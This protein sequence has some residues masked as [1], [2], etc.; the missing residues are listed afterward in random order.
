MGLFL[1]LDILGL[2]YGTSVLFSYICKIKHTDIKS[3]FE[4][5]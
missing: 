4:M 5:F 2:K 3:D 1:Y